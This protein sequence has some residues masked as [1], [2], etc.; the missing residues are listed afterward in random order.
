VFGHA[1]RGSSYRYHAVN[2]PPLTPRSRILKLL[3]VLQSAPVLVTLLS[4]IEKF[5]PGTAYVPFFGLLIWKPTFAL[6][7][8]LHQAILLAFTHSDG[9][10]FG[11]VLCGFEA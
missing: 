7:L 2:D 11:R 3:L 4:V 5:A 8:Y 6:E 1:I 10:L 9:E